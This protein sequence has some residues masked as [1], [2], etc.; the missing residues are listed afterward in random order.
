MLLFNE[1][2][3]GPDDHGDKMLDMTLGPDDYWKELQATLHHL[4]NGGRYEYSH[5]DVAH[6]VLCIASRAAGEYEK[7]D[8]TVREEGDA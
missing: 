5:P 6:A 1:P 2:E 7:L 8:G 3:L 4:C